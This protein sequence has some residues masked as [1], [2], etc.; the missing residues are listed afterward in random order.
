MVEKN[1]NWR[2][3]V[4]LEEDQNKYLTYEVYD[5]LEDEEFRSFVLKN[6]KSYRGIEAGY[7]KEKNPSFQEAIAMLIQMQS[8]FDGLSL[9]ANEIEQRIDG[10]IE[11]YLN[12]EHD[13][14]DKRRFSNTWWRIAA[15]FLVLVAAI[16]LF[17]WDRG[18]NQVYET[19]FGEQMVVALSDGST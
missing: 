4:R 18:V 12:R 15:V 8:H 16:I 2:T 9:S 17:K 13:P 11:G 7:L 6:E 10:Q 1:K 19:G 5:F 14:Y 3:K